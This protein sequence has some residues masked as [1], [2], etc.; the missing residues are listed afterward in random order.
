[1]ATCIICHFATEMD[2]IV[3]SKGNGRCV[4]LRCFAQQTGSYLPMPKNLRHQLADALAEVER[5]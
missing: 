1:M 4:C 3:L 5:T 2:D